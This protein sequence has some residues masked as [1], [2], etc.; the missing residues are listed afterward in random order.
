VHKGWNIPQNLHALKVIRK[1][2]RTTTNKNKQEI[3][4]NISLVL[5]TPIQGELSKKRDHQQETK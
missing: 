4:R 2:N 1:D 3:I 5:L